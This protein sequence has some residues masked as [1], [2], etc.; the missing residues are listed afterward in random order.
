MQDGGV[1]F[2]LTVNQWE[3]TDEEQIYWSPAKNKTESNIM[4][5]VKVRFQVTYQATI[6]VPDNATSEEIGE[7]LADLSIPEWENWQYVDDSFEL[8]TDDN[9]NPELFWPSKIS[10]TFR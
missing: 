3:Y 7:T 4:K 1:D 9:G 5:T 10:G 8:I 2:C 6:E